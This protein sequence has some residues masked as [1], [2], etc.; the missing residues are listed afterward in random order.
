MAIHM[1][2]SVENIPL[3]PKQLTFGHHIIQYCLR[4]VRTNNREKGKKGFGAKEI[5][6]NYREVLNPND[7]FDEKSKSCLKLQTHKSPIFYF[8]APLHTVKFTSYFSILMPEISFLQDLDSVLWKD[9]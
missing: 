9:I 2:D 1:Q 5:P 3:R 6:I 4:G 8:L 7:L